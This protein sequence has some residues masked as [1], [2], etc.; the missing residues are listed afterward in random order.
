VSSASPDLVPNAETWP[1][2]ISCS[3]IRR[4]GTRRFVAGEDV[5]SASSR[6]MATSIRLRW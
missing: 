6:S 1:T 5:P 3:S 4:H 2:S